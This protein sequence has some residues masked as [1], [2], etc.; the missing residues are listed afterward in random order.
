[1]TRAHGRD[2]TGAQ[3]SVDLRLIGLTQLTGGLVQE[4]N[5]GLLVAYSGQHEPLKLARR[6][7]V[8]SASG[9]KRIEQSRVFGKLQ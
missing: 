6:I 2:V 8:Q 9:R 4:D 1:M 3:A 5:A 7:G